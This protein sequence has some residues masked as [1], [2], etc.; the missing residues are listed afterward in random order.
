MFKGKYSHTTSHH[1][2][3]NDK[4][5]T[6]S[7]NSAIK[8]TISPGDT[9]IDFG[10]GSGILSLF[11]LQAGAKHVYCVERNTNARHL[12]NEL[13]KNNGYNNFTII[14]DYRLLPD[15]TID[16]IISESIGDHLIENRS[17]KIFLD[18]CKQYKPKKIIPS[19]IS[20]HVYPEVLAKKHNGVSEVESTTGINLKAITEPILPNPILDTGYFEQNTN[21]DLYWK[22]DNFYNI[23][24]K[25]TTILDCKVPDITTTADGYI[26]HEFEVNTK[27]LKEYGILIYWIVTLSKNYTIHNHPSRIEKQN[28]SYYQRILNIYNPSKKLKNKINF[29]LDL[30]YDNDE[31]EDKPCQNLTIKV[32]Q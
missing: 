26:K 9:V 14:D 22:I 2:M 29:I 4:Y 25:L 16:A 18:L 7:W 8:E 31:Y 1:S 23:D 32:T 5:R 21:T 28:H 17:M 11:A 10:A 6:L 13:L 3:I 12:C 27:G 15:T 20:L 30:D 19:N 24:Q